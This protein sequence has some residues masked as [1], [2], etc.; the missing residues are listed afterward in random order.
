MADTFDWPP[1]TGELASDVR[2]LD[3]AK[4]GLG[5]IDS[6]PRSLRWTVEMVLASP[7]A[8]VVKWGPDLVQIYNDAYRALIG[9]KHARGLGQPTHACWPEIRDF[10]TPIYDAVLRGE[11]RTFRDQNLK[12]RR[13]GGEA[14]AWFDLFY[15]PVRDDAEKVAG[16]LAVV[17]ETTDRVISERRSAAAETALRESEARQAFLLALSDAIRPMDDRDS[18]EGEACRLLARHLG[19]E[20]AFYVEINEAKGAARIGRDF[21]RA[22]ARSLAGMHG[23]SNF[24][25]A[26]KI[27]RRGECHAISDVRTSPLVPEPDRHASEALRIVACMGAP[28]MKAGRLLGAL[29]VA[30]PA[31]RDWTPRELDLMHE[32]AERIRA[33]TERACAEVALRLGE[34]KYRHLFETMD[35]GYVLAEVVRDAEGRPIDVYYHEGNRAA[36]R[37][38]GVQ[39]HAGRRLSE[40]APDAEPYWLEIYDRVA[41]SGLAEH[42]EQYTAVIDRWF[43]FSVS[44]VEAERA[45]PDAPRPFA[46]LFTDITQRKRAEAALR[47]SEARHRALFDSIDEGAWLCEQLPVGADGLR[48]YRYVA[49]NPAMQHMFGIPDLTGQTMRENFPDEDEAWYDDFARVMETGEP[50][51]IV[52]EAETQGMVLSMFITRVQ[53]GGGQWLLGVVQD[54]TAQRRAEETLRASEERKAFLLALSDALQP[55]NDPVAIQQEATRLLGRH[56]GVSR[57]VYAGL[58]IEN[59]QEF[60]VVEREYLAEGTASFAGR[61][62]AEKFTPQLE[63]LRAGRAVVIPDIEAGEMSED[64][65][66]FWRQHGVRA[67]LSLPLVKD[68]RLVTGFGVHSS[69]AREWTPREIELVRETA[70]RS[71]DAVK[72]ARAEAAHRDSE[73][74][75]LGFGEASLDVLWIRTADTLD[76]EYLSPAFERIYGVDRASGLAGGGLSSWLDLIVPEDRDHAAANIERV[77]R[78]ETATFEY[79]VIR[80]SDGEIRWLR[81]T[82][83]PILGADGRVRR[84]GGVGHDVTEEKRT[85][86]RLRVLVAELQHRT[87]NLLNVVRAVAGRTLA[88]S[89]S[90]D[91]FQYHF[92]NRLMA[93]ARVNGLLSRLE[94]GDRITFDEL[95]EAELSGH[96]LT[97]DERIVLT[98][99][100]GV[101]LRST[102]VQT[103]ALAI[104]ELLTN[105]TKYGAFSRPEGRLSIDWHLLEHDGEPRLRVEWRETGV[106]VPPPGDPARGSGY[107]RE[108]IERALPYQ[109]DAQTEY[110]L[111]PDG[112][113]C[114]VLVPVSTRFGG[115]SRG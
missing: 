111:G 19:V 51:R 44:P 57:V 73:E 71:W 12:L 82:D 18:I 89:S 59:G 41:R 52:R 60:V 49:M 95:L 27:L 6:W 75:L 81:N 100:K 76:W 103:L 17:V 1:G 53:E 16:V 106:P 5:P 23:I 94:E 35:E 14:E 85:A 96:G 104:H 29:C 10:T 101:P 84:I 86:D 91:V 62:P 70:E 102:T 31:P 115:R 79:R 46:V 98:G 30:D 22:D 74:R 54:I 105:A 26:V 61:H 69:E 8:M 28:L 25:W 64:R 108:L 99:P 72:R 67:R 110:D 80:P 40:I 92:Q 48:D 9:V 90:L 15:S 24:D 21:V 39:G 87:R 34:A 11:S 63:M 93:L 113:R 55:L 58:V 42:A 114:V 78:G 66:A 38:I 43:S 112:L 47:R 32:V 83:F 36:A 2:A 56:L 65:R 33:A 50:M 107:G 88:N 37:L 77:R 109:L 20:R 97:G 68:G 3:W 7:V 13:N 4:T 45:G